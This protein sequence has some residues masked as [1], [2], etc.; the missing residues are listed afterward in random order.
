MFYFQAVVTF[1][2]LVLM[3]KAYYFELFEEPRGNFF[4]FLFLNK[5]M[6]FNK[7]LK[8]ELECFQYSKSYSQFT[9]TT[10]GDLIKLRRQKNLLDVDLRSR[11][12]APAT[13]L[14]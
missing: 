9:N 3:T 5:T 2:R 4:Y 10:P 12:Q 8:T 14:N 11:Y 1:C 13:R 7:N 6:F